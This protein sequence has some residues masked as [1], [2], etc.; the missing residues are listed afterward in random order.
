MIRIIPSIFSIINFHDVRIWVFAALNLG[1]NVPAGNTLSVA[2]VVML[3]P[4]AGTIVITF[5]LGDSRSLNITGCIL[6]TP[7]ENTRR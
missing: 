2:Y 7:A 1:N 4:T 6:G 3:V 5:D